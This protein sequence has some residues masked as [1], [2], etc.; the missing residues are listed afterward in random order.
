MEQTTN[1]QKPNW[2]KR[3]WSVDDTSVNNAKLAC[4]QSHNVVFHFTALI[5]INIRLAM[6]FPIF[7]NGDSDGDGDG[8][9][10]GDCDGHGDGDGDD[11]DDGDGVD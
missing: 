10:D 6:D 2:C 9:S 7:T 5:P 11:D 4:S 1:A 8:D 3:R